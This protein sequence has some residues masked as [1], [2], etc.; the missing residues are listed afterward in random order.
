MMERCFL[1]RLPICAWSHRQ[2]ASGVGGPAWRKTWRTSE[3]RGEFSLD[4]GHQPPARPVRARWPISGKSVISHQRVLYPS[5]FVTGTGRKHSIP[6][7]ASRL[8]VRYC[9]SNRLKPGSKSLEPDASD[10]LSGCHWPGN[11]RELESTVSRAAVSAPEQTIRAD[12]IHF[13]HPP[14]APFAARWPR[15]ETRSGFI[16]SVCWKKW[17]GTRN[18]QQRFLKSA[19]ARCVARSW[20]TTSSPPRLP[21]GWLGVDR[22]GRGHN[23][24]PSL[25][26]LD[27]VR[28]ATDERSQDKR[29]PRAQP[30]KTEPIGNPVFPN[31]FGL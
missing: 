20:N 17:T 14:E 28:S 1:M 29:R 16:Y 31:I 30:N 19:E 22:P 26:R 8:L 10:L 24:Q 11:I 9:K 13:L 15:S 2:V 6:L 21:P 5:P 3:P 7:L 12:H 4:F 23:A 18:R 27:P 25:V